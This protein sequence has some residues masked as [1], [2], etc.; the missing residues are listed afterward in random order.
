[1]MDRLLRGG[2]VLRRRSRLVDG[3]GGKDGKWNEEGG[4]YGL[5]FGEVVCIESLDKQ[6][7][8]F[9]FSVL[10]WEVLLDSIPPVYIKDRG[11]KDRAFLIHSFPCYIFF[12]NLSAINSSLVQFCINT[13]SFHPLRPT[14]LSPHPPLQ[15][16]TPISPS[17]PLSSL[18]TSLTSPSPV[19]RH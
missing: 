12:L 4:F 5:A 10:F 14:S 13:S 8:S 11:R 15:T 6:G 3:F 9:F 2:S 17:P 18:K 1:M 7:L 19:P 16:N